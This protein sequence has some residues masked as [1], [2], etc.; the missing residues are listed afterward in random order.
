[1]KT[2]PVYGHL[3]NYLNQNI[4]AILKQRDI[5]ET[6]FAYSFLSRFFPATRFPPRRIFQ[7]EHTTTLPHYDYTMHTMFIYSFP[8]IPYEVLHFE[9]EWSK[10]KNSLFIEYIL[11]HRVLGVVAG[12]GSGGCIIH[13]VSQKVNGREGDHFTMSGR[14]MAM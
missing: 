4:E 11:N 9:M 12:V 2:T 7:M 1:M 10:Q 3:L 13:T 8:L 6:V 14:R 5:S